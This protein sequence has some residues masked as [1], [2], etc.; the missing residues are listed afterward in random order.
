MKD[1]MR[2]PSLPALQWREYRTSYSTV[3]GTGGIHTI[4]SGTMTGGIGTDGAG[5]IR[6]GR[7]T[8]L[9]ILGTIIAMT[10]GTT[11]IMIHGIIITII[12]ITGLFLQGLTATDITLPASDIQRL[13]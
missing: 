10:H 12:I 1:P 2:M 3:S 5:M 4:D 8:G 9:G 11:V 6:G 13:P 7:V